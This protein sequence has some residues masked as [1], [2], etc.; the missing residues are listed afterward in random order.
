MFDIAAARRIARC[1]PPGAASV[2]FWE[3]ARF[4]TDTQH[5][6][7]MLRFD[8]D[9]AAEVVSANRWPSMAEI[10]PDLSMTDGDPHWVNH[11]G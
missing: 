8:P 1:Y 2:P 10:W 7:W 4:L 3:R 11:H 9:Q 5:L 6:A